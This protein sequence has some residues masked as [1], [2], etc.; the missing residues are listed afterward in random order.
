MR[1]KL[2]V[3]VFLVVATISVFWQVSNHDFV[4]YDDHK[5]VT[6]NRNVQ[7]GLTREG[8][9]WAFTTTHASTWHPLTWLSHMLDCQIYGLNAGGHHLTNLLFHIANTLLLFLILNRLTGWLNKIS[10]WPT[11]K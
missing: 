4:N 2:I 10:G 8:V 11:R 5:Y 1:L 9:K 6:E 3:C 7:T